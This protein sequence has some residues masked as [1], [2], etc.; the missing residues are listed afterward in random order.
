MSTQPTARVI[1]QGTR[2][3]EDDF[4]CHKYQVWYRSSDCV[5]RQKNETFS[6]CMNCFQG[7]LNARS[8]ERGTAPPAFLG[9]DQP[10]GA[11]SSAPGALL[12]L[13]PSR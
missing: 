5:Y 3:P 10:D 12:Q 1:P 13:R 6:G 2:G 11:H 7:H 4:F 8:L 9:A